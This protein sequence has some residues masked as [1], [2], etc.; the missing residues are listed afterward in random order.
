MTIDLGA[1]AWTVKDNVIVPIDSN[2]MKGIFEINRHADDHKKDT[3][4]WCFSKP[5]NPRPKS[6]EVPEGSG[7]TLVELQRFTVEENEIVATLSQAGATIY[8]DQH[9]GWVKELVLPSGIDS[10]S[11]KSLKDLRKL[12]SVV[13]SV[14]NKDLA[15]SLAGHPA[16]RSLRFRCEV[17]DDIID[18]LAKELP[19]LT[20]F[21]LQCKD[22]TNAHATAIAQWTSLTMLDI[23]KNQNDL[24]GLDFMADSNIHWIRMFDCDFGKPAFDR[25]ADQLPKLTSLSFSNCQ[26]SEDGLEPINRMKNLGSLELK[27]SSIT[28]DHIRSMSAS[29]KLR[30]LDISG[31][32]VTNK[33]LEHI[34]ENLPEVYNVR[35]ERVAFDR[36][37]FK[38]VNSVEPDRQF[39][40]TV[41][42]SSVTHEDVENADLTNGRVRVIGW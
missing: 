6:F 24:A 14:A 3:L 20:F 35:A 25:L 27:D 31:T 16:L 7:Q 39:D 8:K 30:S 1:S 21:G 32:Q 12:R 33:S 26:I 13:S 40:V 17:P 2:S 18:Q 10:E 28:D 37:I 38:I 29:S 5:G 19:D 34:R 9:G 22:L 36:G 4:R 15:D 41:S 11:L 42:K 23:Y